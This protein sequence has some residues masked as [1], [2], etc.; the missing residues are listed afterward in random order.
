MDERTSPPWWLWIVA[1]VYALAWALRYAL[2]H[3]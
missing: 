1:I 3:A 2:E